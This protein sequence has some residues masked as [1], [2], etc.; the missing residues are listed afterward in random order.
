MR[1]ILYSDLM[2]RKSFL[3]SSSGN[4]LT[5]ITASS[6]TN[7]AIHV[8]EELADPTYLETKKSVSQIKVS[9]IDGI[10]FT[11]MNCLR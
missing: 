9:A 3:T 6:N 11:W 1:R 8:A 5:N 10:H 7:T 4:N 2:K